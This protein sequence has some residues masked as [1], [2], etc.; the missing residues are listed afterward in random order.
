VTIGSA[1]GHIEPISDAVAD[2]DRG[3]TDFSRDRV[4]GR[5][6]VFAAAEQLRIVMREDRRDIAQIDALNRVE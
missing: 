3:T 6:D 1:I 2:E 4:D 5:D